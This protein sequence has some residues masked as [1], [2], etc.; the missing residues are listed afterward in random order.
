[1][2]LGRPVFFSL[3][4]GGQEGVQKMLSIIRDELEA[5]M[6][7]CG[8]QVSNN[9]SRIN[10][11]VAAAETY[12]FPKTERSYDMFSCYIELAQGGHFLRWFRLS[13]MN[14]GRRKP[15]TDAPSTW[16]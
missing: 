15:F 3:A 4:V 5:A 1:M 2:L 11:T 16:E 8:C 13:W 6:A 7:L 12:I 9:T 10:T 14:V